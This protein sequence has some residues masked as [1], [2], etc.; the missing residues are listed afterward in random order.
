MK[1]CTKCG[2]LKAI[3]SDNFPKSVKA[4]DGFVNQCKVCRREY[5]REYNRKNRK[6]IAEHKRKKYFENREEELEK[7][8]QYYKDNKEEYRLYGIEYRKNNKEAIRERDRRYRERNT[9]RLDAYYKEWAKGKEEYLREYKRQHRLDNLE[10]IKEKERIYKL[11]NPD[12]ARMAGQR[13][14]ARMKQLPHD[15][16]RER[17][18]QIV[19]DF[20]VKCAYCG[21]TEEEHLETWNEQL[22]QEHFVPLS[23]GGEYTA[24]NIIPSCRTCN[25]RK[26]NLDFFD[27]YPSYEF[28]DKNRES[29]ILNYLGYENNK[30]QLSI[31]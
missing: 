22:H 25:S 13:Y 27:W 31:L 1:K 7:R 15:L 23:G 14:R 19:H 10:E 26:Q 29:F 16:T 11:E 8:R 20:S 24:N 4:I 21:M 12:V 30:Q 18:R 2:E 6:R 28:Y 9:E 17:W 3:N 5:T